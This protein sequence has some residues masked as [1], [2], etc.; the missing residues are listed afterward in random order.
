MGHTLQTIEDK[1][2]YIRTARAGASVELLCRLLDF[3]HS[4]Y[5]E[6]LNRKPSLHRQQDQKLKCQLIWEGL[7]P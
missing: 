7:N 6:W 5:Y 3:S 4:G 1:Y 2:Q